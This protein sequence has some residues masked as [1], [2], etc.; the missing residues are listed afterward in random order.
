MGISPKTVA[1]LR[2]L[3]HDAVHL[4]DEGLNCL[5][6]Y[7][8]LCKARNE[9]RILLTHDLDFAELIAAGQSRIPSVVVFRLRKMRPEI[10]NRYLYD[11]LD[12]HAIELQQ[13][14][15][16]SVSEGLLRVRIL[17]LKAEETKE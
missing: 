6:D 15:I 1:Y 16:V 11:V 13:G 5:S 14:A 4:H 7:D 17:P 3:N 12:N 9:N 2:S 8:I 10:V